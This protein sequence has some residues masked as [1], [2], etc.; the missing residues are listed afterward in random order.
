MGVDVDLVS[1][2]R[3]TLERASH[4]WSAAAVARTAY[5]V[6]QKVGIGVATARA[7]VAR[8]A[9]VVRCVQACARFTDLKPSER[10]RVLAL[11]PIA[12][13]VVSLAR[14]R[15]WSHLHVAF[16][17]DTGFI[18]LF[19]SLLGS[20][21]YSLAHHCNPSHLGAGVN[22]SEKWSRAAFGAAVTDTLRR[23]LREELGAVGPETVLIA[24]MGVDLDRFTRRTPYVPWT[25]QGALQL[26]SC[27]RLVPDKGHVEVVRALALLVR[28]GIDARLRIAGGAPD[29]AWFS[30]HLNEVIRETGMQARVTLLGAI[31]EDRVRD[32]LE[33]A[34]AFVLA[35]YDEGLGIAF[36]EAMA[37]E[38]P[39]VGT[40][41][42]GVPELITS[43]VDGVLV[44]PR[45]PEA[46]ADALEKLLADP[47]VARYGR[48]ARR[49]VEAAFTSSVGAR[50]LVDELQ[51]RY[52]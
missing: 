25:G 52:G 40:A 37:M 17:T 22:M 6:E 48:A 2:R 13:Q 26:F 5:L 30:A 49:R 38:L 23:D 18:A 50:V 19:A 27:G 34:H 14:T 15:G 41:V 3:P 45:D 33:A 11:I 12:A 44:R 8:P 4:Q 20:V 29:G 36:A 21:P 1:T 35:T 47:D 16:P 31:A 24:P 28:R 9:G 43:G 10:V 42:G 7:V 51:R 32:E 39:V 46:V